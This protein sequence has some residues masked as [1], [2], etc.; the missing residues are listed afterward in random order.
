MSYSTPSRK[1]GR[2]RAPNKK[3]TVDAFEGLD[4]IDSNSEHD[5]ELLQAS[6][7]RAAKD[8]RD[9]HDDFAEDD[10][11]IPEPVPEEDDEVSAVEESD[12]SDVATP[13]EDIEE[14]MTESLGGGKS[15]QK[16]QQRVQLE[17]VR[18][19]GM[20]DFLIRASRFDDDLFL[21]HIIGSDENEKAYFRQNRNKWINNISLPTRHP[22]DQGQGGMAYP[23]NYPA[24]LRNTEATVGW[25]WYFSEGGKTAFQKKQAL[26]PLT[27]TAGAEYITRPADTNKSLLLG[28]YGK[29]QLFTLSFM[30]SLS[31]KQSWKLARTNNSTQP[32]AGDPRTPIKRQDG[33]IL[34]VGTGVQC[35]EWAPTHHGAIQY[36]AISTVLLKEFG[37]DPQAES[38]PAYTASL[39]TPSS[40]QIWTFT[41]SAAPDNTVHLNPELHTVLCTEWGLA[42]QLKWCPM[43]RDARTDGSEIRIHL[44][45]LAGV[46]G[47][48]YVRVL[49][50]FLD[51]ERGS[52]TTYGMLAESTTIFTVDETVVKY[53]TAAFEARPPETLCTCV[54]WLSPTDLAVGCANGYL[55]VWNIFPQ[56]TISVQ[57]APLR[58]A[59]R[60]KVTSDRQSK[61]PSTLSPRPYLYISIHHTYILA[62]T[63]AYPP[64]P[65]F[66]CTSAASGHTRLTDLRSPSSDSVFMPHMRIGPSFLTYSTHLNSFLTNSEDR[67]FVRAWPLRRFWTYI[68]IAKADPELLSISTAPLHST[69]LFGYADGTLLAVNPLRRYVGTFIRGGQPQHTVW[70][71]EWAR[72]TQTGQGG[73]SRFTEGY[74]LENL[75]LRPEFERTM[76]GHR[77]TTFESKDVPTFST[78]YEAKSALRAISWNPNLEYGG[79]VAAGL[80]S[81]LVRVEDLAI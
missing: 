44:G 7:A 3:Y 53:K 52:S 22:N 79:W 68:G 50:V 32:N 55:A 65:H 41:R 56:N 62:I 10:Q 1:S 19:R 8:D 38:A 34:N 16:K 24:D 2:Q 76:K 73:I 6:E 81:G 26:Q 70:K 69:V 43:P 49:D 54:T 75:V 14:G 78:I 61:R 64:F 4:V 11:V 63:S 21:E 30:Q 27:S 60:S 46:W 47:D 67:N 20:P 37:N 31:L 42:R 23:F 15:S 39:P 35:L 9:G 74:K 57:D 36:L 40:I 66:L 80:G 58:S 72:S 13:F 25:D 71:H 29:Q 18:S 48:G 5:L 17:D 33:W 28:P 12:G 77:K 45:L 59:R 51:P